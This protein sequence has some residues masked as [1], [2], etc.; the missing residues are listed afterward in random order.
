MNGKIMVSEHV[1]YYPENFGIQRDPFEATPDPF[2]YYKSQNHATVL[3]WVT[4][5]IDQRELGLVIGE[6]GSGK[7]VLARFLANSLDNK[8]YKICWISDP[9][10]TPLTFL[11]TICTSLLD[12]EPHNQKKE[13]QQQIKQGLI[14]LFQRGIRPIVIVEDAHEIRQKAIFDEIRQLSNF[15]IGIQNLISIIMFGRPALDKRL[16]HQAY[17]IFLERLHFSIVLTPLG[18]KETKYY[19]LNRLQLAGLIA[20]F[21]FAE[22]AVVRIWELSGGIPR[23]INQIASLSM[24]RSAKAKLNEISIDQV[25]AV[26]NDLFPRTNK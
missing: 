17:H 25:N 5:A 16:K 19:L 15:Q 26:A 4:E 20:S 14:A 7:T 1:D 13:V 21:P 9:Q 11:K 23:S 3:E 12:I 6:Q 22:D 10:I 18:R 8:R 24:A 2:F